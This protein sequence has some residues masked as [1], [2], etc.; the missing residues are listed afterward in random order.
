MTK[1]ILFTKDEYIQMINQMTNPAP[2]PVNPQESLSK[3]L[4][5]ATKP[6]MPQP[7][8]KPQGQ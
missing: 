8:M 1:R 6:G 3:L 2:V 4:G 7:G 5:T